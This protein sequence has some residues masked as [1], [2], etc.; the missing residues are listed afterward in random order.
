[1]WGQKLAQDFIKSPILFNQAHNEWVGVAAVKSDLIDSNLTSINSVKINQTI[2]DNINNM[3]LK[4]NQILENQNDFSVETENTPKLDEIISN[5]L[6]DSIFYY[7]FNISNSSLYKQFFDQF[8]EIYKSFEITLN[9]LIQSN[10][11]NQIDIFEKVWKIFIY[12]TDNI[13]IFIANNF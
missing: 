7:N 10:Q 3:M 2:F 4:Y 8:D 13:Y 6:S 11:I 5:I 9:T 12:N 1:M